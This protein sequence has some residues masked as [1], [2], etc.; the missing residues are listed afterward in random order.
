MLF[1]MF[2][3][4]SDPNVSQISSEYDAT[5]FVENIEATKKFYESYD[6]VLISVDD[7][8]STNARGSSVEEQVSILKSR[9]IGGYQTI[10][11]QLTTDFAQYNNT[12]ITVLKKGNGGK[13]HELILNAEGLDVGYSME[14]GLL[15]TLMYYQASKMLSPSM[16]L[17]DLDVVRAYYGDFST[18]A[19]APGLKYLAALLNNFDKKS[20][21]TYH[22][23]IEASMLQ[24]QNA[25]K[26]GNDFISD[27]NEAIKNI[28]SQWEKGTMSLL[29]HHMMMMKKHLQT[30]SSDEQSKLS[31]V[32][33]YSIGTGLLIGWRSI[34][35]NYK[36]ISDADVKYMMNLMLMTE[37]T[38]DPLRMLEYPVE[39]SGNIEKCMKKITEIYGISIE[40]LGL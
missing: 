18:P 8:R 30:A 11:D 20:G 15:G 2:S 17:K 27:K 5:L 31:F 19:N 23:D 21:T 16:S 10:L 33:E 3:C 6:G 28:K 14:H 39:A 13:M 4:E 34:L 22:I 40:E 9:V 38:T 25:I 35:N 12:P 24:L 29:M 36:N 1:A 26:G 37:R 32:K 7:A